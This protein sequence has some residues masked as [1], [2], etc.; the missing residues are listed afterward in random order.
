MRFQLCFDLVYFSNPVH[1]MSV[2]LYYNLVVVT[3]YL[4]LLLPRLIFPGLTNIW[5][6]C[7]LSSSCWMWFLVNVKTYFP[8]ESKFMIPASQF[9]NIFC[10]L[11]SY[12]ELSILGLWTL[13]RYKTRYF[14]ISSWDLENND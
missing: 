8:K 10:F 13:G 2:M 5:C 14:R 1:D 9:V 4:F 11:K 3:Y 12:S 6:V 7:S